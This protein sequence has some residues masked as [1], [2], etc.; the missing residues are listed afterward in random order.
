MAGQAREV[1]LEGV[2]VPRVMW[3]EVRWDSEARREVPSSPAPRRRIRFEGGEDMVDSARRRCATR[4][5]VL[6]IY[7][8]LTSCSGSQGIIKLTCHL[9]VS[10]WN[11]A[12]LRL[13]VG[14]K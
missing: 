4:W 1:C 12:G 5:K 13:H 9:L 7:F 3:T 2:R 8:N 10:P 14:T 6:S 11:I